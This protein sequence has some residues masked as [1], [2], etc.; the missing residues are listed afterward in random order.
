MGANSMRT[1]G[2]GRLGA[3]MAALA[4]TVTALVAVNVTPDE[5][6]GAAAVWSSGFS[7]SQVFSGLT[8]PTA[9]QFAPDG[10][11]FVAEKDGVVKVS[12]SIND[13]TP[14]VFADLKPEV[15]SYVDRGLLSLTVDPQWPAR[16]YVYVLYAYDHV[17]GDPAPAPKYNDTCA[18]T[19]SGGD[20]GNCVASARLSRLTATP[21]DLDHM[22]VGGEKVLVEDWCQQFPIHINGTVAFGSDGALYASHGSAASAHFTDYG[23]TGVPTNPC[24]DPPVPMG[25]AQTIP[26]AEGGSLRSQDPQTPSDPYTLD[27]TVIRV[28]PDT[29][30]GV[31]GN[32]LFASADANARRIVAYGLRMPFRIA[33]RPN[34]HEMWIG[35]LDENLYEEV[36]RVAIGGPLV[37]AGW[38]CYEDGSE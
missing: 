17:L 15:Y 31:A 29:G 16:P 19:G 38:P 1:S 37:T 22:A 27:G 36:D 10:K 12:D 4:L 3:A 20:N 33:P 7:A 35:A 32:P 23:Q 13:T 11:V 28:D 8:L 2:R 6:A 34:A 21:G 9:F 30:A 5:P 14:T 18:G 26:T 25:A 24:G